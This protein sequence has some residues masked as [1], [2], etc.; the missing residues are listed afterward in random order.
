MLDCCVTE[1][2]ISNWWEPSC[3]DSRSDLELPTYLLI[4][5]FFLNVFPHKMQFHLAIQLCGKALLPVESS[6]P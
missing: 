6:S 4:R 1:A 3:T 5:L 2:V